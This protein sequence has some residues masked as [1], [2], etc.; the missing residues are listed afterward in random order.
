VS[1]LNGMMA[2]ERWLA[3]RIPDMHP[4]VRRAIVLGVTKAVYPHIRVELLADLADAMQDQFPSVA[5]GLDASAAEH[6]AQLAR[7]THDA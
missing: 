6:A 2:G 4:E 1:A 3:D 7:E 5:A